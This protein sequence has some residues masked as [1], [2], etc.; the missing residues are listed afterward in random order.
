MSRETKLIIA[1]TIDPDAAW[2]QCV[3]T[4]SPAN[5][6]IL[7]ALAKAEEI[8]RL[9]A[10]PPAPVARSLHGQISAIYRGLDVEDCAAVD[11]VWKK[12][13]DLHVPSESVAMSEDV[14]AA[15]NEARS[16]INAMRVSPCAGIASSKKA[17]DEFDLALNLLERALP[18]SAPAFLAAPNNAEGLPSSDAAESAADTLYPTGWLQP[19]LEKASERA[20]QMPDWM[21]RSNAQRRSPIASLPAIETTTPACSRTRT[22]NICGARM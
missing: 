8:E 10:T 11:R 19:T 3:E 18:K 17:A 7:A 2:G 16:R 6:R 20:S 9:R 12:I 5:E 22:G 13:R 4:G 15:V 14:R 21:T 1:K